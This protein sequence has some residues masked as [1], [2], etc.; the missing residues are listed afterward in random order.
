MCQIPDPVQHISAHMNPAYCLGLQLQGELN[1]ASFVALSAAELGSTMTGKPLT[2]PSRCILEHSA[3]KPEALSARASAS[4][5]MVQAELA[6]ARRCQKERMSCAT[7][8]FKIC[9]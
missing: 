3:C 8:A 2:A 7:V 9:S 6:D 4:W 1:A 5:H